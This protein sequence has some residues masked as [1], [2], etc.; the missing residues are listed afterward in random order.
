MG[1]VW[2]WGRCSCSGL[3][4]LRG[5]GGRDAEVGACEVNIS[6]CDAR[7]FAGSGTSLVPVVSRCGGRSWGRDD[8]SVLGRSFPPAAATLQVGTRLVPLLGQ[9]DVC[10]GKAMVSVGWPDAF[11]FHRR[12]AAGRGRALDAGYAGLPKPQPFVFFALLCGHSPHARLLLEHR[13]I[14]SRFLSISASSDSRNRHFPS[15][16]PTQNQTLSSSA[17]FAPLAPLRLT[18]IVPVA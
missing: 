4:A 17:S 2:C 18:R 15:R 7:V 6:R 16:T 14:T 11:P 1:K 10:G 13:T 9:Q 5:R 3:A 8:A 12:E